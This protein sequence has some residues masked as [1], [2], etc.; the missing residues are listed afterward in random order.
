MKSKTASHS[1]SPFSDPARGASATPGISIASGAMPAFKYGSLAR[2]S[3]KASMPP[4]TT[5]T[6]G[7]AT[8][9]GFR[10]RPTAILP[11]PARPAN[12]ISTRDIAITLRFC[13]CGPL[14]VRRCQRAERIGPFLPIDGTQPGDHRQDLLENCMEK[15]VTI[16]LCAFEQL[17]FNFV[18]RTRLKG[19]LCVCH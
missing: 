19:A 5:T 3:L 15:R 14:F 16:F 17:A 9:L 1:R 8:P 11:S 13:L 7:L 2:S 18:D 4:Q 10:R 6:G 12:G